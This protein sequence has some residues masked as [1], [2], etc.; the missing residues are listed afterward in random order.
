VTR[1]PDAGDTNQKKEPVMATLHIE[2][3][4][5]DY[6]TW[7]SVFDKFDRMRK[8]QNVRGYRISRRHDDPNQIVIDLDFD[9][10]DHAT[11]F[12]EVL[13]KIWAT[14]QSKEQLVSH[15]EPQ[16]LELVDQ[17]AL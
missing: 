5:R 13:A 16:V 17:R 14:P 9:T 4:V 7:K 6:P 2:N 15:S 10:A 12:R 3:T 8:E 11:S 1:A